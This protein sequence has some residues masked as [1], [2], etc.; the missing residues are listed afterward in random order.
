[1]VAPEAA[2]ADRPDS[3]TYLLIAEAPPSVESGRFFY[4]ERVP[5][6]DS[7]FLEVMKVMG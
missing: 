4:F 1:V 7:L 6:G 2:V 3:V 5:T